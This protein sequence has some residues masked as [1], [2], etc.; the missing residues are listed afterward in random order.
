MNKE[1][2]EKGAVMS[3]QRGCAAPRRAESDTVLTVSLSN[4]YKGV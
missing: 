2:T 1:P 3:R 4:G